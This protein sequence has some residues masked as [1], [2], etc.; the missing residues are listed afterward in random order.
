MRKIK[1]LRD[2]FI[3]RTKV[4][5]RRHVVFSV[6]DI[7]HEE[8]SNDL[9]IVQGEDITEKM[10]IE[11]DLRRANAELKERVEERTAKLMKANEQLKGEIIQRKQAEERI[12]QQAEFLN[13]VL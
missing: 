2:E 10:Q 9:Q 12:K 4:G 13:L 1:S 6:F 5:D 8:K 7:L 11:E 3:I